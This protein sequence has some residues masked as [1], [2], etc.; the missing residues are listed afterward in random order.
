[1]MQL[2]AI[3]LC[4]PLNTNTSLMF[5]NFTAANQI[6]IHKGR[7][8]LLGDQMTFALRADFVILYSYYC[9]EHMRRN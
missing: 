8:T 3:L 4:N 2:D 9:N 1:M 5:V 6:Y 7:L